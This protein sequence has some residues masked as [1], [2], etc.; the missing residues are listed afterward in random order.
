MLHRVRVAVMDITSG[1]QVVWAEDGTP[2]ALPKTDHD[3][4]GKIGEQ[5]AEAFH[6]RHC[7][8]NGL[9]VACAI[10]PE[11]TFLRFQFDGNVPQQVLILASRQIATVRRHLPGEGE[12]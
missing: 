11:A 5:L 7:E 9:L 3:L 10:D 4:Q 12:W 1:D 2:R 6:S 8:C